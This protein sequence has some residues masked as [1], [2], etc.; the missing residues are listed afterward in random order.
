MPL[1]HL[2][3]FS[4]HSKS[5]QLVRC[6]IQG[7]DKQ[8]NVH[9]YHDDFLLLLAAIAIKGMPVIKQTRNQQETKFGTHFVIEITFLAALLLI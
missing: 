3:S 1:S 7:R 9:Y 8:K 2:K 5:D 4:E 6:V